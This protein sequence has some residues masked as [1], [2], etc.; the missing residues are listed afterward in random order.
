MRYWDSSAIVP[1]LVQESATETVRALLAEDPEVVVWSMTS[2]EVTSALWR[3]AR[4]GEIEEQ[5]R[6][7]A[8]QGLAELEEAWNAL[9]DVAQIVGRAR[10]LLAVH[11]LRAA[12]AAQLAAALI[13]CRE[14]TDVLEFVTLDDRLADAARREGLRV[15]PAGG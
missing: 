3:R 1:L 5:A 7:A 10:R 6:M 13:A 14:H 12:D 11:S 15:L 2:L 4:A 8:S 9:I